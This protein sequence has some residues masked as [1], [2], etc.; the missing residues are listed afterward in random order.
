MSVASSSSPTSDGSPES[1]SRDAVASDDRH[2][3][4]PSPPAQQDDS[5]GEY[6]PT[7]QSTQ[8]G[9]VWVTPS[10]RSNTSSIATNARTSLDDLYKRIYGQDSIR[11]LLTLG[12]G[13]LTVAHA[14][15]RASKSPEVSHVMTDSEISKAFLAVT[16]RIL[17][18]IQSR[19]L[20]C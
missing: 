9:T 13:G 19:G 4:T 12:K 17:P 1:P 20:P 18:R 14:I 6:T 3:M 15:R 7:R 10:Q 11:C 5:H 8:S 16:V 2:L